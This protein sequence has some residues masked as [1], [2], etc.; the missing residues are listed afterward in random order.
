MVSEE[1]RFI[2]DLRKK[3]FT[4]R[5]VRH[6]NTL[7]VSGDI[8]GQAGPVSEQPDLAVH[9]PAHCRGVGIDDLKKDPSNSKNSMILC[10]KVISEIFLFIL[11]Y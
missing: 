4:V 1:G 2:L 10:I 8:Q 7:P 6:W 5:V 9:L 3:S 11:H